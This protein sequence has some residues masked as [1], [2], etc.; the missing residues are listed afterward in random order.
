[1]GW[2]MAA[3]LVADGRTVIAAAADED[4]EKSFTAAFGCAGNREQPNL[5]AVD[6]V[7]L[8]LPTS[9]IVREVLLSDETGLARSI[10]DTAVVVDMSSSDPT[11]TIAL[12]K[13]LAQRGIHV[14]DAPVSGGVTGARQGTLAIMMGAND[15]EAKVVATDVVT[16]L[17]NRIFRTAALGSAHAMKA[18]NSYVAGATFTAAAEA[19]IIGSHC[20]LTPEVMVDV[21]NASTG[22]GFMTETSVAGIARGS[23]ETGFA[24]GLLD[25]DVRIA[26][27]LALRVG[28]QATVCDAVRRR[29]DLATEGLGSGVDSACAYRYWKAED[30]T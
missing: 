23:Y 3:N 14:V 13:V 19:L 6:A 26:S 21:L 10:P 18:L 24:L 22:R 2:P 29:L 28:T 17:S 7:A 8:M 16:P 12:A 25:K 20:R 30:E 15:E 27:Q 11:D 5:A 4:R 1:M 9:A